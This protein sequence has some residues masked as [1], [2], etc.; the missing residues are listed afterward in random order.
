MKVIF[1]PGSALSTPVPFAVTLFIVTAVI[2]FSLKTIIN[3]F[4]N[5]ESK[6]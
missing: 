1:D 6:K 5:E 4:N 2:V 3:I